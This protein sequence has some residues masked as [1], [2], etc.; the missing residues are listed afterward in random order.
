MK[1]KPSKIALIILLGLF[2]LAWG[3]VSWQWDRMMNEYRK[4]AKAIIR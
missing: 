3:Y 1:I 2:L 4:D